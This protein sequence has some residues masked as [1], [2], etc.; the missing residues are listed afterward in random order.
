M[1]SEIDRLAREAREREA[2]AADMTAEREA[3]QSAAL[4][5][6]MPLIEA[7]IIEGLTLAVGPAVAIAMTIAGPTI[8]HNSRVESEGKEGAR[9]QVF[10]TATA[11]GGEQTD[12]DKVQYTLS[13]AF[14]LRPGIGVPMNRTM[15]EIRLDPNRFGR[16]RPGVDLQ[17]VKR[18]LVAE[19]QARQPR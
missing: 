5:H 13:V 12:P 15:I 4:A 14:M 19:Y 9:A 7:D 1:E 3:F 10:V 16:N 6:V 2:V 11:I 17:A 18:A 8:E